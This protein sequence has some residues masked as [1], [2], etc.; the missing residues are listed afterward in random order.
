MN[1]FNF[2]SNKKKMPL[3]MSKKIMMEK[4]SIT[5]SGSLLVDP[6][7]ETIPSEYRDLAADACVKAFDTYLGRKTNKKTLESYVDEVYEIVSK[8]NRFIS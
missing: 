4:F 7:I 6:W 3:S 1:R 5:E 8:D 2:L